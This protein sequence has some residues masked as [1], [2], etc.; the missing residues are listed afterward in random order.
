[1][2]HIH[3][4]YSGEGPSPE[5]GRFESDSRARL[6]LAP[7]PVEL[8]LAEL[9]SES[10]IRFRTIDPRHV[11][12]LA[13]VPD[14]WPPI[15]VARRSM[16]VLDGVHRVAAARRLGMP[17]ITAHLFDGDEDQAFV[18]AVRSNIAHGLP[19]SLAERSWAA[20]RL[21]SSQPDRSDRATAA[22]CGLDH[23]TVARLRDQV[24]SPS[25]EIPRSD[26]RIGRDHRAR[27]IDAAG[28]RIRIAAALAD[29]PEESLRQIAHRVGASPETVRD[30]RARLARGDDPVPSGA[31][32]VADPPLPPPP[33]VVWPAWAADT[34]CRSVP[35][36]AEFGAW[37]DQ[38]AASL[39]WRRF[40]EV[41][42]LSRVY[43]IADQARAYAD[44]WRH[45]A[46]ALERRTRQGPPAL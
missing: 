40:V 38:G 11:A 25:G 16:M 23:K 37:F 21:L 45:F 39:D 20:R 29:A 19:L 13:E 28:L 5:S 18:E 43:E 6:R 34:A 46:E 33:P 1:M 35:D 17:T 36:A 42:P 4:E 3:S 27:P 12:V 24:R 22:I 9:R 7:E 26:V 44:A 41:V 2:V 15:L 14:R 10:M 8:E 32:H 31:R 30:V